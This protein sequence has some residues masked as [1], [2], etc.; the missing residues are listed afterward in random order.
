MMIVGDSWAQS[1]FRVILGL[2]SESGV[3]VLSVIL[4]FRM[5]YHH[6]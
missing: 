1:M 5:S 6:K 3:H 2:F 4:S